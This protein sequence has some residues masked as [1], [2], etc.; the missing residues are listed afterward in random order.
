LIKAVRKYEQV[1]SDLNDKLQEK[2]SEEDYEDWE[3]TFDRESDN[4]EKS[5]NNQGIV[6]LKKEHDDYQLKNNK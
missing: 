3:I 1:I 4:I 5:Y 2:L 6:W